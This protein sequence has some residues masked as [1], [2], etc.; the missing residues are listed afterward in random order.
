MAN[1][2]Q[3]RINGVSSFNSIGSSVSATVSGN[4]VSFKSA[5]YGIASQI[6]ISD[7]DGSNT[8]LSALFGSNPTATKGTAV[9]GSI[10]GAVGS[11]FGQNLTGATGNAA[12]GLNIK[13]NTGSTG[14]RGNLIYTRGFAYQLDQLTSQFLDNNGL[15]ATRTSGINS[16]LKTLDTQINRLQDRLDTLR[17]QYTKQFNTLDQTMSQMNS[18][19]SYLTQQLS[20][21][22]KS[23]SSN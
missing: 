16:S 2:I 9:A 5:I 18:T 1:A 13:V 11:G 8:L 23:S 7:P 21:L 10:N 4:A 17:Q 14:S 12:E 19:Q 6:Q 15:I 20:S 22:A 3:A